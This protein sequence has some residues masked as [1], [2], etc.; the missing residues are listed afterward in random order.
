MHI[1]KLWIWPGLAAVACLTALAIWF[2]AGGVEADLKARAL[3]ALR[4]D[5]AW[6]QVSLKGRDLTLT[7]LAPDQ[8]SRSTALEIAGAVYGV[9]VARDNST[10]LPEEKPYRFTA[11]KTSNGVL[12]S[13][14]VPNE[15]ARAGIITGLSN[16][17][18]GI[19]VTDQ[20]KLARGA[21]EGL[22]DLVNYGMA[23]FT[24]F[25]TGSLELTDHTLQVSGHALNPDDHD[26]ALEALAAPPPAGGRVGSVDITPAAATNG[27]S[28]SAS[29]TAGS[30][31]L[32]GY[33]P[34][35][36][37]RSGIVAAVQAAHPDLTVNDDMRFATGVPAGVDWQTAVGEALAVASHLSEGSVSI[38]G[39]V[40]DVSGQAV[41]STH[42][43]QVQER[44]AGGLAGGL[45]LGTADIG[46]EGQ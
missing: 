46:G 25:S 30:M 36:G 5:S 17:L 11:E 21:P 10:L 23:A 41:D 34:D 9:R 4:Q 42:F 29:I 38:R 19:A 15:A 26:I 3:A 39:R 28:W 1:L 16:L 40:L 8:E 33:A 43:R 37:A 24:R 44:L 12:L 45:V 7:G 13:G 14:F 18:P 31:D 6:A 2:E 20:M 22:V 32:T 27:Y 35:A